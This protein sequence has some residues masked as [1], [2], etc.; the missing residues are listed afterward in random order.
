MKGNRNGQPKTTWGGG[1]GVGGGGGGD[2]TKWNKFKIIFH[3]CG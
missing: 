2:A 3:V 1:W